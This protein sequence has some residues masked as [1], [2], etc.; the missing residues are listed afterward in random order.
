[1]CVQEREGE[2]KGQKRDREMDHPVREVPGVVT[3]LTQGNS[4]EQAKALEDYFLPDAYLIH[5]FCRVPPFRDYRPPIPLPFVGAWSLNSRR[6]V[7]AVY[8]WYRI[9]SPRIAV[10]IDSIGRVSQF[11]CILSPVKTCFP[12]ILNVPV[13]A[14][15]V[16]MLASPLEGSSLISSKS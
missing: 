2:E 4:E 16:Y 7:Q 12:V 5:P 3:A 15:P 1:M 9:L 11:P 8:E 6:L 10:T 14:N 13:D